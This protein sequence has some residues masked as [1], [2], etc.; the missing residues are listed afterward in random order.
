[1]FVKDLWRSS[2][3]VFEDPWLQF[4]EQS[5]FT[6]ICTMYTAFSY[7][8]VQSTVSYCNKCMRKFKSHLEKKN[9]FISLSP[10]VCIALI[11]TPRANVLL[12]GW[13]ISTTG[14][15]TGNIKG[16]SNIL[17][18]NKS[19]NLRVM[20]HIECPH[21][22]NVDRVSLQP[23]SFFDRPRAQGS[24]RISMIVINMTLNYI[25]N[26]KCMIVSCLPLKISFLTFTWKF[27]VCTCII[28]FCNHYQVQLIFSKI[29]K[30]R[31]HKICNVLRYM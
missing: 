10:T 30:W 5:W 27:T 8:V 31:L 3:D 24:G 26:V 23:P 28:S 15:F 14:Q 11:F 21:V 16:P 29:R 12:Y 1:M 18:R 7:N 2:Q 22:H 20:A 6:C 9:F 19:Y 25:H 13:T 17:S 4:S